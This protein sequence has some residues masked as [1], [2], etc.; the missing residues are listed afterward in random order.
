MQGENEM[1]KFLRNVLCVCLAGAMTFSTG[2]YNTLPTSLGSTRVFAEEKITYKASGARESIYCEFLP[3]TGASKYEAVLIDSSNVQTPIDDE[4]IRQYNTFIRVDALGL[5]AGSYKI[6]I[7]AKDSSD[8]VIASAVTDA[9]S[10]TDYK[11]IGFAFPDGATAL[12]GYNADGTVKDDALVF[13]ITNDN[14][15]SITC[16]IVTNSKGQLTSCTGLGAIIKA[17][18]KGYETRSFIF[19][20]IGHVDCP[21]SEQKLNQLDIKRAAN[22]TFEGVGSDTVA[23]FGFNIVE[24]NSIE[25]RNLGFKD[26]TTKDEDAVTIKDQSKNIWIHNNDIFYG[27]QGSDADQAKGDGGVDLKGTSTNI[28]VSENHY[29]DFGK[30][31]LCGLGE[32][33]DYYVTYA[34]NW[35]DHTDSRHPRIRKGSVHIFNNYYD[36]VSKYGVGVT[37]GGSAFVEGNYFR[38]TKYP[39][40][41]SLQGSDLAG[42]GTFSG[43]DGGIIKLF[44]NIMAGSYT[45]IEGVN[46]ASD[47]TVT[48]SNEADGYT[49]E[50]RNEK[51]PET[52]KCLNGATSYNNF[53][54][55]ISIGATA[56]QVLQPNEVPA[57]VTKN[58]GRCD[59]GDFSFTFDNSVDDTSYEV[60]SELT[61]ALA[62]Y[63]NNIIEVGGTVTKSL[64]TSAKPV[65]MTGVDGNNFSEERNNNIT[66][67]INTLPDQTEEEGNKAKYAA[68]AADLTLMP[69]DIS[70]S[71]VSSQLDNL[72]TDG[73]FSILAN[74]NKT[75][76]VSTS[77]GIQ[78][79]GAGAADY[80]CIKVTTQKDGTVSVMSSSTGDDTRVLAVA[81]SNGNVVGTINTGD[82]TPISISAGTYFIYST[83]KGINVSKVSVFYN[84]EDESISSTETSTEYSTETSTEQTTISA[85]ES[86]TQTQSTT[87]A[88]E[89]TTVTVE[90]ST[91]EST[92]A[93]E[94]GKKA[95][96][97]SDGIVNRADY[98][99]ASKFF[100]GV[101]VDINNANTDVNGD[102]VVTRADYVIIAKYFAGVKT[103]Y[104]E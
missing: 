39:T 95:D 72:G 52:L 82:S 35:F 15:D 80:R 83:N 5:K 57:Y 90:E 53:D 67:F 71:T 87:T 104:F 47:G 89:S 65:S 66:S 59:G 29:W 94:Q 101:P 70:V 45:F 97:N 73:A 81:D 18:E 34:N 16:D 38:N 58:A 37:S 76:S 12:G 27:G 11:R 60:N 92:T 46:R 99:L 48:Y 85:T 64:D 17:M 56:S 77:K 63:K 91:I 86:S 22:I 100:A 25:I 79:G 1:K 49:V 43:E 23:K 103:G 26:M 62:A 78:L 14:K 75:V 8:N 42:G 98:V 96:I 4:L 3:V 13:Y 93:S 24:S 7:T 41:I 36:G 9:V 74:S 51:L 21:A 6:K 50:E 19:R 32:S 33:A 69:S 31:N 84:T 10:S 44:N 88:A 20:F 102:N 28:T 30:V 40:L 61:A 68:K 55:T 2:I 54:T